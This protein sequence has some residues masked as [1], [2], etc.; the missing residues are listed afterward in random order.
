KRKFAVTERRRRGRSSANPR[1]VPAE[2][3]NAVWRRDGGR[4]TFVAQGGHRCGERRRLGFDHILPVARGGRAA[5]G[6]LRLRCRAHNQYEA[7]RAF[8]AE[9]MARKREEALRAA[10]LRK[11]TMERLRKEKAAEVIPWLRQLGL[12]ADEASNAARLCECIPDAPLEE[13]GERAHSGG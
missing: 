1:H 7:E 5:V 4:C 2:V 13:R 12:K 11:T 8:G 9:F 10:G 6:H 3:R